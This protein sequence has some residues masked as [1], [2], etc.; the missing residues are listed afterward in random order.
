M[1]W[2]A[3]T[4]RLWLLFRPLYLRAT[5]LTCPAENAARPRFGRVWRLVP[6]VALGVGAV[7]GLAYLLV[8]VQSLQV[9]AVY[10]KDFIQEFLLARA[11]VDASHPDAYAPIRELAERYLGVVGYGIKEYPTPHPTPVGVLFVPL[12]AFDYTA[13]AAV[14]LGVQ[15]VALGLAIRRERTTDV[16]T[17]IPIESEPPQ[18]R[19]QLGLI[20]R[21]GAHHVG[22]FDTKDEF[23]LVAPGEK[24]VEE[25]RTRVAYVHV[26]GGA[27]CETHSHPV[28]GHR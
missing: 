6:Q 8:I 1:L 26:S 25:R 27:R 14:W 5:V 13:A 12:A 11:F 4:Q 18:V 10:N 9:P 2:S 19:N 15:L 28:C 21:L 16:R 24:P 22:I 7:Y 23:A 3:L 17:F 20:A